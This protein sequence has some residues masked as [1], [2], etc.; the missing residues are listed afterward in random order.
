MMGAQVAEGLP[1]AVLADPF[2]LE[3]RDLIVVIPRAQNP[4]GISFDVA[5]VRE[6]ER[7][8]AGAPDLLVIEDDFLRAV[9]GVRLATLV[10]N[11]K[12]WMH[13]RSFAKSA[14]MRLG[15][16]HVTLRR[17]GGT[18][19]SRNDE[20]PGSGFT[21]WIEVRDEAAAVIAAQSAG[22]TIDGGARYRSNVAPPIR[23]TTTTLE[24]RDTA[25]L[26][27]ALTRAEQR[28][29]NAQPKRSR[30]RGRPAP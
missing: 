28:C 20:T 3:I 5:R 24:P 22:Y 29:A 7:A 9:C 17:G 23:V 14:R 11:R 12:T 1:D 13:V 18:A 19:R 25:T 6:L 2:M 15:E 8:L 21:V 10:A 30:E 16:R 26:A 4:T 27:A